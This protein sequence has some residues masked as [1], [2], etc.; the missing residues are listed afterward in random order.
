MPERTKAVGRLVNALHRGVSYN[1]LHF[2]MK[3][4][5][6]ELDE[7]Q[8]DT[9]MGQYYAAYD[10]MIRGIDWNRVLC[11]ALSCHMARQTVNSKHVTDFGDYGDQVCPD[12]VMQALLTDST[13]YDWNKLALELEKPNLEPK[14]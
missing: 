3:V 9:F 2:T 7:T 8:R 13:F 14:V 4:D 11:E 12:C 10:T 6:K 5:G 1:N